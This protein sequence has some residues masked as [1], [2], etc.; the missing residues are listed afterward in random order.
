MVCPICGAKIRKKDV[1]CPKCG[2]RVNGT[3]D[4]DTN[5]TQDTNDTSEDYVS[6]E[7]LKKSITEIRYEM[8][9]VKIINLTKLPI[10]ICTPCRHMERAKT[11]QIPALTTLLYVDWLPTGQ[12]FSA[13][14]TV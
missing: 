11:K 3:I 8:T 13:S 6:N 7:E 14:S 4:Q 9:F 1:F 10:R 2:A 12:W 5:H